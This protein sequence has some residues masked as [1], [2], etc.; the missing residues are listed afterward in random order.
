MAK[1]IDLFSADQINVWQFGLKLA[2]L[3]PPLSS[4]MIVEE[5]QDYYRETKR[6]KRRTG[7][8]ADAALDETILSVLVLQNGG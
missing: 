5:M 3:R 8:F 7:R 6:I 2:R 1:M 4:Q